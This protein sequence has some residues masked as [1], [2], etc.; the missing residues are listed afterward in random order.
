MLLVQH[1]FSPYRIKGSIL[2]KSVKISCQ[3]SDFQTRSCD[4]QWQRVMAQRRKN[5]IFKRRRA[6]MVTTNKFARRMRNSRVTELFSLRNTR[7]YYTNKGQ[8]LSA[9]SDFVVDKRE[10]NSP[11][12][13]FQTIVLRR[14]GRSWQSK[15]YGSV[16]Y[17]T[18]ENENQIST[19]G[20]C[21]L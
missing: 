3:S 18:R 14:K 17:S 16:A 5:A 19:V 9:D 21:N 4:Y 1:H 15:Q 7:E 10:W 13:K 8:L 6:K 20:I 12:L 2:L 11:A